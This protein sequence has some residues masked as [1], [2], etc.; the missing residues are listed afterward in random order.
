MDYFSP[1]AGRAREYRRA[2]D[3]AL[4]ESSRLVL[5]QLSVQP[6]SAEAGKSSG[7]TGPG[8][9]D[10]GAY[11]DLLLDPPHG[12]TISEADRNTA[13][14]DLAR[15]LVEMEAVP[16][17]ESGET[18]PTVTALSE[19]YYSPAAVARLTRWWDIEPDN[20]MELI[21]VSEDEVEIARGRIATAFERLAQAV[22]EMR[23]E[24]LAIVREIIVCRQGEARLHSFAGATSFALWGA[25]LL[26]FDAHDA[27]HNYYKSIVH[28]GAHNLL[29]AIARNEPL[30]SD[31]PN[32][33]RH[34]PLRGQDRP[35]DGI[36]HAAFVT[37]RESLAFDRLISWHEETGG[38]SESEFE[39]AAQILEASVLS[40]WNCVQ[41]VRRD[42]HLTPLGE[43][44]LSECEQYMTA[45]FALVD[46]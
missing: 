7:A 35:I 6:E 38:L 17:G 41:A 42:G 44:I 22:P 30:V 16:P 25:M 31:D 9:L 1:S 32:D 11:F 5:E 20:A 33:W 39:D 8:T 15:R 40:F 28:E 46:G 43:A 36:F 14:E 24:L 2:M 3:S 19:A 29:F 37:A 34:S 12:K 4:L 23:S 27:W 21:P 26:N 10:Y 13:S 45:N 18:L